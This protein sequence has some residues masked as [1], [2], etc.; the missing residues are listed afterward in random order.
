MTQTTKCANIYLT[1]SNDEGFRA[2]RANYARSQRPT[3]LSGEGIV[4]TLAVEM[5]PNT[6]N[7]Q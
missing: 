6:T 3:G 2:V 5:T 7:E 4:M 1:I